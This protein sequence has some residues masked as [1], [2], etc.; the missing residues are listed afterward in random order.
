V[1]QTPNISEFWTARIYYT[2]KSGKN[3]LRP[4]LVVNYEDEEQL[5][6]IQEITTEEQKTP[7]TYFELCKEVINKWSDS[8]LDEKS[9][10]KCSPTNTHRVERFR[11]KN[12][13]GISDEADFINIIEKI[14]DAKRKFRK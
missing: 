12:Y 6:T 14:Q 9:F 13:I 3:K 11:L 4:V 2:G 7:L 5:Y 1:T 8:G 10:I